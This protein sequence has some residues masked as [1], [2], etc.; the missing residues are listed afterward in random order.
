MGREE[1]EMSRPLPQLALMDEVHRVLEAG[2]PDVLIQFPNQQP[3]ERDP[4]P[5]ARVSWDVRGYSQNL[6]LG[7]VQAK[8]EV[9]IAIFE[10]VGAGDKRFRVASSQIVEA[11]LGFWA[12]PPVIPG[13]V[14]LLPGLPLIHDANTGGRNGREHIY[15][16]RIRWPMEIIF[17]YSGGQT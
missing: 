14:K 13:M 9:A 2:C 17:T 10:F 11:A 15:M 16:G 6:S 7:H 12:A 1:A 3:P 8:I 5:I 4:R